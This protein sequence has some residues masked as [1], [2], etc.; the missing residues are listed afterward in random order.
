M[1]GAG[2]SDRLDDLDSVLPGGDWVAWVFLG[3]AV[4]LIAWDRGA[5]RDRGGG[6]R[7]SAWGRRGARDIGWRARILRDLERDAAAAELAGDFGARGA[8]ALLA[9][10][11]CGWRT[12]TRS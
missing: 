4:A 3:G 10:A 7:V 8:A 1:S 11:C 9:R 2:F 5:Q 12:R 6:G